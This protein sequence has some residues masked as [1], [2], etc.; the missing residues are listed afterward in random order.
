[1]AGILIMSF[2][3]KEPWGTHRKYQV[4][5]E[6]YIDIFGRPE[7]TA[8][9]ILMLDLVDK[10]IISKLPTLKNQL[11]AKYALTRFAILFIL[12]QIFENDNKGKEL[13]V[14][15]ELFVKD[16]KDRQDFIDST[17]TIINDIIID[18]NGEVENLGEDFDYKS[19]L[20][21]ENWIK[22][23]SQEIVSSY[24]KQVSRQRIESFENEWNKRIASR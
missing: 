22:K 2:D 15:P 11:V 5:D 9:R 16:L 23:L 12:R 7:V 3:L 20:R 1:M 18:F 17:S 14:S 4:F 21:D 13:L 19:K 10:I 6:K 24:L 8:H